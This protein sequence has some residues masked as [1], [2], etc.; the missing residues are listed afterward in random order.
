MKRILALISAAMFTVALSVSTTAAAAVPSSSGNYCA[1][2]VAPLGSDADQAEPA[3]FPSQAQV[4]AYLADVTTA[5][6]SARSAGATSSTVLGTVY[7]D[8]NYS[9]GSLSF[10]GT[11][12]CSA[13]PERTEAHTR[14][15]GLSEGAR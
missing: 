7:K 6:Q 8:I 2:E 1:V 15:D 5:R 13:C 3:C 9:G 10:Y 11:G 14:G 12:S 4:D